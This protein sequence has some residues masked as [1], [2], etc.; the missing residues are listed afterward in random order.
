MYIASGCVSR[1]PEECDPP[2]TTLRMTE[3]ATRKFKKG[4]SS[5]KNPRGGTYMYIN[6]CM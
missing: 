5:Q 1:L 3:R 4:A 2:A 6:Y